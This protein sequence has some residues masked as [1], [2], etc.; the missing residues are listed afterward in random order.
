MVNTALIRAFSL[1][2]FNTIFNNI[3]INLKRDNKRRSLININ[4]QSHESPFDLS[5]PK[6]KNNRKVFDHQKT[7]INENWKIKQ[8][9][10]GKKKKKKAMHIRLSGPTIGQVSTLEDR[11]VAAVTSDSALAHP[12]QSTP[13]LAPSSCGHLDGNA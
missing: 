8:N 11:T 2:L 5:Q 9:H 1:S 4:Y 7:I 6:V 10:S 3:L 13:S 12:R